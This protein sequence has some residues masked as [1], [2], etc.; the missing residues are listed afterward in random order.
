M[1]SYRKRITA[2]LLAMTLA[3]S[4]AACGDG[5]MKKKDA[6]EE[7]SRSKDLS[8][9]AYTAEVKELTAGDGCIDNIDPN[10]A[11]VVGKNIYFSAYTYSPGQEERIFRSSIFHVD[12]ETG[13]IKALDKFVMPQVEDT[14][15]GVYLDSIAAGAD[16]TAW[17]AV[18]T[19][20]TIFA[21]PA[22]FD[23]EKDDRWEHYK[24][25]EEH[26]TWYRV[27]AEGNEISAM[28]AQR[29]KDESRSEEDTRL[30]M[31]TGNT[32]FDDDGCCYYQDKDY[33]YVTDPAKNS[34]GKIKIKDMRGDLVRLNDGTVGIFDPGRKD[35]PAAVIVVDK[36]TQKLGKRYPIEGNV[37]GG[38]LS[39][40]GKYLFAYTVGDAL[41]GYIDEHTPAE[42]FF[43]W[44][45]VD[46]SQSAVRGIS[47][48]DDGRVVIL[49]CE[50]SRSTEDRTAAQLVVLS[51]ADASAI[52][53]KEHLTLAYLF[54]Q[55]DL[56]RAVSTFNRKSTKFHI[57][58]QDYSEY[59][60][61][62]DFRLGTTKLM[63]EISAGNM[64]DMLVVNNLP[65]AQ[66]AEKGLFEDLWPYIDKD[67]ELG[68]DK[69]MLR[70]LEAAQVD[71]M[72]PQV[73]GSFNIRTEAASAEIV[74]DRVGWTLD[75]VKDV[76][77]K[78]PEGARL[79]ADTTTK[80]QI[81][82]GLL[83]HIQDK[84]IDWSAGECYYDTQE[85]IDILKFCDQYGADADV[86]TVNREEHEDEISVVQRGMQL[87]MMC[88][89]NDLEGMQ[90]E[91]AVFGGDVAYIGDPTTDGRSGG[92]FLGIDGIAMSS[93]C[94]KKE[95][96]WSFMRTLL[97]NDQSMLDDM[98]DL[99]INKDMF[100]A[101]T[102]K[103][104]EKRYRLDENGSKVLDKNGEPIE[105]VKASWGMGGIM[106]DIYAATQEDLDTFMEAYNATDT[107][108]SLNWD[109]E[110][111]VL[112]EAEAFF[113]GDKT[114]EEAAKQIQSRM[115]LYIN[116]QM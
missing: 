114:T 66:Y 84:L 94:R 6:G 105:E 24:G 30:D 39:G 91:H 35:R 51:P 96:A 69:L 63:T 26:T 73:F 37:K 46:V 78:L 100:D 19:S 32:A 44:S 50:H 97:L 113:R 80:S 104:M 103:Q 110:D 25:S 101:F 56:R 57:D 20:R 68:R 2:L 18:T 64:P 75:D 76:M 55:D 21:L 87:L 41:Y 92:V 71:G 48:L 5:D 23:E 13:E 116:E 47:F 62:D 27:D 28:E 109:V 16:G 81:L 115:K 3:L 54:M 36:E 89:I 77:E 79:Y 99:P 52:P 112:K 31:D 83:V 82:S 1:Y 93:K 4:L 33:I 9:T 102:K 14:D 108:L 11:A 106:I 15:T 17:V 58:I 86:D 67:P 53:E 61:K 7:D 49:T 74:G 59:N 34:T 22:D 107:I 65:V 70:P 10:D 8:G 60:T 88:F 98:W 43:A 72:L 45:S 85:F 12:A 90:V 95:A 29:P 38:I 111:I 40:S 42:R